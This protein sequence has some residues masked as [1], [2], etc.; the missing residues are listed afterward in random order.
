MGM[1]K[2][3]PEWKILRFTGS[4]RPDFQGEM[5]QTHLKNK[6]RHSA[7]NGRGIKTIWRMA[8]IL[9]KLA[10]WYANGWSHYAF[11]Y[12]ERFGKSRCAL[13]LAT[14]AK[15]KLSIMLISTSTKLTSFHNYFIWLSYTEQVEWQNEGKCMGTIQEPRGPSL[16]IKNDFLCEPYRLRN[17][18]TDH[19]NQGLHPWLCCLSPSGSWLLWI[20]TPHQPGTTQ[21]KIPTN[22]WPK[23]TYFFHIRTNKGSC[24]KQL[25]VQ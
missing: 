6:S 4:D 23:G 12:W 24:T 17:E 22:P 19:I 10:V 2:F 8:A 3:K 18:A 14:L 11:F 13:Y 1:G 7:D 21:V 15:S 16:R 5:K 25:V 9:G 20:T